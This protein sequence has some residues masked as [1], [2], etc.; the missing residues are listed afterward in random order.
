MS[1]QVW[2]VGV[3]W[4]P[5]VDEQQEDLFRCNYSERLGSDMKYLCVQLTE[6]VVGCSRI[7]IHGDSG[8]R[9]PKE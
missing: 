2:G 4:E 8:L 3:E 9:G 7:S 5:G 1:L 6:E